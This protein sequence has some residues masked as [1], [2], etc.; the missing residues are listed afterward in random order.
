MFEG[1][2]IGFDKLWR[3]SN[4][5][6]HPRETRVPQWPNRSLLIASVSFLLSN[7]CSRLVPRIISARNAVFPCL[8]DSRSTDSGY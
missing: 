6:T 1:D 5:F 2:L 8:A 3:A 7:R 4:I